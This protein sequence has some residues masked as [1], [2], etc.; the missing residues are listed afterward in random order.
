MA[1][2]KAKAEK[3]VKETKPKADKVS[4][5]SP[6]LSDAKVAEV[7]A[8]ERA[9]VQE[10]GEGDH[11]HVPESSD[12]PGTQGTVESP[13]G[14]G[15][16]AAPGKLKRAPKG[17]DLP[18]VPSPATSRPVRPQEA[19][20]FSDLEAAARLVRSVI[21]QGR[22]PEADR[23]ALERFATGIEA[24]TKNKKAAAN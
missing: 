2:A 10:G 14:T 1:A 9:G 23:A 3:T 17:D 21:R 22:C 15:N 24:E 19:V 8:T 20:T 16:A 11:G 6:V 12:T 5:V 13:V 4:D 18:Q 7:N